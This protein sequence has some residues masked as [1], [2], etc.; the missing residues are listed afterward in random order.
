[1]GLL[2]KVFQSLN[3][4]KLAGDLL[5]GWV[6]NVLKIASTVVSDL[7][8]GK[9][10]GDIIK[11]VAKDVAVLAVKIAITAFTGGTAGLFI[12]QIIDRAGGILG[13]VAGKLLTSTLA[14]PVA[15]WAAQKVTGLA[16]SLTT[17]FVRSGLTRIV[18]DATGLTSTSDALDRS[19][20]DSAL[21]ERRVAELFAKQVT[22]TFTKHDLA[23]TQFSLLNSTDAF[24]GVA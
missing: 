20:L 15:N 18:L 11:D 6:G 13:Q 4:L 22:R 9:K 2:S 19:R 10:F 5:G 1:M 17:D 21:L 3:P 23:Q 8:Q 7:A 12:N 16:S 14:R 24:V